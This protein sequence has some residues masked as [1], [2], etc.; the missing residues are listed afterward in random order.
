MC[1]NVCNREKNRHYVTPDKITQYFSIH[2]E[3]FEFESDQ[4]LDLVTYFQEIQKIEEHL[5]L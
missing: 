5:E 2:V 1:K 3:G 4:V